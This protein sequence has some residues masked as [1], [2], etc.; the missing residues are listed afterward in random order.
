MS[1]V[2]LWCAVAAVAGT[3]TTIPATPAA[4]APTCR[5]AAEPQPVIATLPWAQRWLQ[6]ERAWHISRG[7]GVT[8]A[9]V[10]S[11]AD[12]THPQL[13]GG[14]VLAG[15]DMMTNTPGGDGDCDSHGT[16]VASLI[17]GAL[18]PG[19]GFAGLA[20]QARILPIRV[21]EQNLDSNGVSDNTPVSPALA[22]QGIRW[23]AD[24]GARIVNVSIV[25]FQ[26]YPV[27]ADAVG[28]AQSKGAIV[29]AAVGN[30][31]DDT[32]PVDV[33]PYPA[34]Y[35]GVIGVGAIDAD[36]MRVPSSYAGPH[37]DL[38]APGGDVTAASR[39]AGH[40]LRTGTSF[41][42]PF[43]S[44]TA[45]LM[46]AAD[47]NASPAQVVRRLVATAD[48]AGPAAEYGHGVV[49]PVRALT[50]RVTTAGPVQGAP[51]PDVAVDPEAQARA[52]RWRRAG[53]H[54]TLTALGVIGSA[55]L[56]VLAAAVWVRGRKR[57]WRPTRTG[58]AATALLADASTV[59]EPERVFYTVP[60]PP[61]ART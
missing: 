51:F 33:V 56:L 50:E 47:R 21:A 9:V 48:P 41:A 4:A 1:R 14:Q 57:R 8:V 44:A 7:Q 22:A 49:D 46:L 39:A 23:A 38:V 28:Y 40:Q 61:R 15:M 16:A 58:G 13:R 35:P 32:L 10:D 27:L 60:T 29:V 17:A 26:N 45:A 12:A 31:H 6:P 2:P 11:G 55:T 54:A 59:D 5:T 42:A 36:G 37:V 52:E 34:A 24:Q 3:M 19:V 53:D 30:H 20:P 25:F 43:V 18:E